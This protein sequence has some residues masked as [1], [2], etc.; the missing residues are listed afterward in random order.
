[1]T[2]IENNSPIATPITFLMVISFFA[3]FQFEEFVAGADL[4]GYGDGDAGTLLGDGNGTVVIVDLRGGDVDDASGGASDEH[5][6]AHLKG[7][8][9]NG[10][11]C[12][13]QF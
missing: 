5:L 8:S 4:G 1:M 6:I 3:L 11:L 7:I 13:T 2:F 10:K 9:L 12:N